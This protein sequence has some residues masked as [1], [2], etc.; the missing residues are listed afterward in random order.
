M[1]S[2]TGCLCLILVNTYWSWKNIRSRAIYDC[3]LCIQVLGGGIMCKE[4]D[5]NWRFGVVGNIV[6]KHIDD[7]GILCYGTKAFTG[8]TKVYI[9]GNI[10]NPGKTELSVI[11]RNRFGRYVYESV[12]VDSVENIRCQRIYKPV[13]L[14][15]IDYDQAVESAIW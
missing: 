12:P 6:K 2:A 9:H 1:C 11:G 4:N 13:V 10:W 5:K 7:E 14:E 3:K 8:G 15:I